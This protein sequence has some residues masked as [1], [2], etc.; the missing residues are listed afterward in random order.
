M[1]I[2]KYI[3]IVALALVCG[4]CTSD[5]II[6][7]EE[8]EKETLT[9]SSEVLPYDGEPVTR[10]KEDGTAFEQNDMIR[11]KVICPYVNNT[12]Y[13]ESTWGN[14]MDDFWLLKWTGSAWTTLT[15]NDYYD[16]TG[17]YSHSGS[18]N[19]F[20]IYESQPTPYVYTAITWTEEKLYKA[21]DGKLLNFYSN[22]FH[23]DQHRL[24]NYKA[25]DVLWAQQYSQ[26]GTY[27]IRLTFQHVM[28]AVLITID[29]DALTEKISTDAVLTMTNM[30]DIDQAEVVI[31]DYYAAKDKRDYPLGYKVKSS[32][33]YDDHGKV[34]GIADQSKV[35]YF[36]GGAK[37][38]NYGVEI[39]NTATYTCYHIPGTK[40]YR[41][42][43]PPCVLAETK[44]AEFW[45]RDDTRRFK[46]VLDR[47]KFEQGKLY[48]ITMNVGVTTNTDSDS[49]STDSGDTGDTD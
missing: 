38:T 42:I 31:G 48:N 11:L 12:L 27:H 30:P 13:G 19:I 5:E 39:P 21:N 7:T 32:C 45:L 9:I 4:A 2:Q 40:Q 35:D 3:Q 6:P 23:H 33:A 41:V 47:T 24:K 28:A 26:T 46:M 44:K 1:K 34:L 37:A 14:T 25:S 16:I 15:A 20:D 29:D 36:S 18:S 8:K 17:S 49:G 22:V 43:V 10:A